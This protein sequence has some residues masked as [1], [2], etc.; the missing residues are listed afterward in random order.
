M[1]RTVQFLSDVG[2][3]RVI[4]MKLLGDV[5]G[6]SVQLFCSSIGSQVLQEFAY[7]TQ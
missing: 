1:D 2:M 4:A 7:T 5:E 6:F 3:V